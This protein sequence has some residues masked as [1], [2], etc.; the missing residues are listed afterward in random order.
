MTSDRVPDLIS[1]VV[2]FHDEERFLARAIASVV[3]QNHRPIELVL[4]DDA[5]VDQ[6]RAVAEGVERGDVAVVHRRHD[7]NRGLAAARNTGLAAATGDYFTYL[8]GDDEM[9]PERLRGMLDELNTRKGVHVVVGQDELLV[10]SGCDVPENVVAGRVDGR[11]VYLPSM[12]YGRMVHDLVGGFDERFELSEDFDW[13]VRAKALGLVV[14]QTDVL[15]VRRRIHG[16]NLSYDSEGIMRY[17]GKSMA[18][19]NRRR[20]KGL[21]HYVDPTIGIP[22]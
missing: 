17:R 7:R 19:L 20:R 15:A 4:V 21:G 5:S 8:D 14:E 13:L 1:V 6:S 22:A 12:L 18:E 10:E 16:Q 3:E 9:A 2:A 11:A